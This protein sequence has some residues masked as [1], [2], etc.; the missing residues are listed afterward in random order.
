MQTGRGPGQATPE[1][2]E[3]R[4]RRLVTVAETPEDG[5]LASERVKSITGGE[6]INARRLYGHPFTFEPSHTIWV[7]TNHKPR[8]PDDSDAIWRRVLPIPFTITI[9]TA[10]WD[11]DIDVKLAHERPG[12]LR[13]IV[14]GARA[15]LRGGL[16][17][18]EA[19]TAA[20]ASYRQSEDL[21]GAFLDEVTVSE[22]GASAQASE[23]HRT[24][25]AWAGHAGAQPL[26]A[27]ALAEKL[28]AR[29]FERRR[30]KAGSRWYGLR[31]AESGG[32]DV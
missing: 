23:L 12:I 20:A 24:Y 22:D 25:S 8:V 16:N 30:V 15:Y 17:P 2:A 21:F 14:D 27:N 19:V 28:T 18:P 4:G 6:P 32:L 3:L 9:P 26:S 1:L 31:L 13:W 5:R 29:G 11:R 10:E 7:L